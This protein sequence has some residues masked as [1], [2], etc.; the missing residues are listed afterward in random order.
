MGPK[1]AAV[2]VEEVTPVVEELTPV[3]IIPTGIW[4]NLTDS[5]YVEFCTSINS[6]NG[7][8]SWRVMKGMLTS[9][10]RDR[11]ARTEIILDF[12][13]QYL[14]FCRSSNIKFSAAEEIMRIVQKTFEETLIIRSDCNREQAVEYF[15]SMVS[16]YISK[17]EGE[18]QITLT[19]FQNF[20]KLFSLSFIRYFNSFKFVFEENQKEIMEDRFIPVFSPLGHP[21][22]LQ[23]FTEV[24]ENVEIVSGDEEP[25]ITGD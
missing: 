4:L 24:H 20:T 12:M 17:M 7:K 23:S 13:F 15:K 1:K 9:K 2:P 10:A 8:S 18:N 16:E 11:D 14:D 25:D 6:V 22:P 19:T 21:P 3:E 5:L